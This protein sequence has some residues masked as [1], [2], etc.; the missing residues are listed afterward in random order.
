LG[1]DDEGESIDVK[2]K[3]SELQ[4][5]IIWGNKEAAELW[6]NKAIGNRPEIQ[7]F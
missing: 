2:T 7:I 6:R 1:T 3:I 4:E 5:K